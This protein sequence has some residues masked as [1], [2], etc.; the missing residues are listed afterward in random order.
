MQELAALLGNLALQAEQLTATALSLFSRDHAFNRGRVRAFFRRVGKH[1]DMIKLRLL[2][3]VVQLLKRFLCLTG[4]TDDKRGAQ[5]D[6]R[7]DLAGA[8]DQLP[9]GLADVAPAHGL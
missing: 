4:M 2:D 5:E 1:A 9:H 6:V 7:D 3:K 8:L